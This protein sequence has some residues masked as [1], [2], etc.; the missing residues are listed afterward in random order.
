M[1]LP[2]GWHVDHTIPRLEL[3]QD[4][5]FFFGVEKQE[6]TPGGEVVY[7]ND[8]EGEFCHELRLNL[9]YAYPDKLRR[10]AL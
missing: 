10:V 4:S 8:L 6:I 3:H 9:G 7:T 2:A 1:L 5:V